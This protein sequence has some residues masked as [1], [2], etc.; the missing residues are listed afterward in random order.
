M[1]TTEGDGEKCVDVALAVE[2]MHYACTDGALDVAVLISGDKDFMPAMMRTRSPPLTP[3]SSHRI[4]ISCFALVSGC[5]SPLFAFPPNIFLPHIFSCGCFKIP[6]KKLL[7]FF[8]KY[9]C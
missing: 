4:L 3:I 5:V 2:M 7:F 1:S 9:V 8:F 6:I